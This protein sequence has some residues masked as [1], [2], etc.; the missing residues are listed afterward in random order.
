MD[1]LRP[2]AMIDD[3][4]AKEYQLLT[5]ERAKLAQVVGLAEQR[6]AG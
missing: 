3:S 5:L 2:Q 6:I 1:Q 4:A